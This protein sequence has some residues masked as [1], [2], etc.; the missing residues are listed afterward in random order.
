[1][2]DTARRAGRFGIRIPTVDVD[3]A[4]VMARKDDVVREGR[5]IYLEQ[6]AADD[7][8][9]YVPHRVRFAGPTRLVWEGGEIEAAKTIVAVGGEPV[10]PPFPGLDEC[11]AAVDSDGLLAVRELPRRLVVLG[12][13]VLSCEFSQ[14][15]RRFGSEVT[16]VLRGPRVLRD[17]DVDAVELIERRFAAEGIRIVRGATVE[18]L[19]QPRAEGP[20]TVRIRHAGGAEALVADVVLVAAGRRPATADLG[21]E[22]AGVELTAN[23]G[24][25]VDDE[26]RTSA[27]NIWAVGDALGRKLYTHVATY[28]GPIAVRNAIEGRG[29]KPR[30]DAIPG[31]VFTDPELA[32]VGLTAAAAEQQGLDVVVGTRPFARVGKARAIDE[33]EGFARIVVERGSRRILGAV[34]VGHHAADLLPEVLS[35]MAADGTIAAIRGAIHTHPTLSEGVNGAARRVEE[36][37]RG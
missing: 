2:V 5:E 15:F 20:A 16:I 1:V 31:A 9:H 14:V 37:L 4:A 17:E 8:L 3:F 30:Y 25:A 29:L 10:A 13:G 11:P 7:D 19:E 6:I 24:V 21:L 32:S 35:A 28:E 22:H 12:G 23:G 36:L 33:R 26:L 34:I 27:R 18:R